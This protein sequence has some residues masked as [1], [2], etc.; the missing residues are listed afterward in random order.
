MTCAAAYASAK[1]IIEN[2]VP[3]KAAESGVYLRK[4]LDGLQSH[5]PIIAEVRGMGLLLAVE[6]KEDI[7]PMVVAACNEEGLLMNSVRP[8]AIRMMPPLI[9]KKE[10]INLAIERFTR[11]MHRVLEG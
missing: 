9:V 4:Q 3:A 2:D 11:G 1:Y 7:S 5:E 6:F 10:E 8:N